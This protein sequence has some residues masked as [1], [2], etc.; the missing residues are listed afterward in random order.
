MYYVELELKLPDGSVAKFGTSCTSDLNKAVS[1]LEAYRGC[2]E[3][4]V[5]VE[6]VVS[7]ELKIG[8]IP[9][10]KL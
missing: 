7:Y 3:S 6:L 8:N 1:Q 10:S 5:C 2:A 9:N 4:L